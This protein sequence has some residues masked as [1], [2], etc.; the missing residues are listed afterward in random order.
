MIRMIILQIVL[1]LAAFNVSCLHASGYFSE[2]CSQ[3][4]GDCDENGSILVRI[5]VIIKN[6]NFY[7]SIH[8][9]FLSRI[10]LRSYF[11]ILPYDF[12]FSQEKPGC[13]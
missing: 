3:K 7:I 2:Q 13:K 5:N 8:I 10:V 11:F 4:N 1:Y 12:R 9:S 6:W